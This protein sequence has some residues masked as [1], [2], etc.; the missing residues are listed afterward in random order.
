MALIE[1]KSGFFSGIS[2]G[3]TFGKDQLKQYLPFVIIAAIVIVVGVGVG[4][5]LAT[6]KRR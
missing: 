1:K 2:G 5:M 3:I 6:G 4:R